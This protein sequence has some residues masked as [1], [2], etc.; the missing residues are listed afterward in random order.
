MGESECRTISIKTPTEEILGFPYDPKLTIQ[1]LKEWIEGKDP[2]LPVA[3]QRL[4]FHGHVL[5]DDA[6]LEAYPLFPDPDPDDSDPASD[7]E[8]DGKCLIHV[9]LSLHGK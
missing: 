5:Q 1:K 2:T 8:G 7:D 3:D 4:V 6:T 9:V